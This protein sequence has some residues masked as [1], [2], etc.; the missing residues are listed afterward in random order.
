MDNIKQKPFYYWEID[1]NGQLVQAY[2]SLVSDFY[3]YRIDDIPKIGYSENPSEEFISYLSRQKIFFESLMS[4]ILGTENYV[5]GSFEL[6]LEN[7]TSSRTINTFIILKIV[8][9]KGPRSS[10]EYQ[11]QF[12]ALFPADY[13]L[14]EITDASEKERILFLNDKKVVEI[15]KTPR[16]LPIGKVN[17]TAPIASEVWQ[18]DETELTPC[19]LPYVLSIELRVNELINFYKALQ[20]CDEPVMVRFSL[21]LCEIYTQEKL[22]SQSYEKRIHRGYPTTDVSNVSATFTKYITADHLY[23]IKIQV[24]CKNMSRAKSIANIFCGQLSNSGQGLGSNSIYSAYP[25][26]GDPKG[27]EYDWSYCN[28]FHH[29]FWQYGLQQPSGKIKVI[30]TR[31]PY[32]YNNIEYLMPFRIPFSMPAG[33]PG[34]F[35]KPV[36]PF[37]QPNPKRENKPSDAGPLPVK[38]IS[39]GKVQGSAKKAKDQLD[40]RIPIEDL[41]KHGLI[42]GTTGSGK[43]N[44]TLNILKELQREGIPFLLIEPTKSEYHDKLKDHFKKTG[45]PLHV[46]KFKNPF[47][48]DG[49]VNPEFL[50]FNPLIPAPG[51]SVVQHISYIKSCFCA[52]F[53]IQGIAPLVL[54]E[55]LLEQYKKYYA[56]KPESFLFD[57]NES[58]SHHYKPGKKNTKRLDNLTLYNL[59]AIIDKILDVKEAMYSQEEKDTLG[60]YLKR[61]IRFLTRSI[62]GHSFC[63]EKWANIYGESEEIDPN[64]TRIFNEPTIIELDDLADNDEKALIMAFILT[65][66][67]EY[68]KK[69]GDLHITIIE[70]AHRLLGTGNASSPGS[71]EDG[72]KFMEDSKSKSINLFVDML[73]EIRAKGEG[74]L[75]VEQIP[76]KL[77][78]DAIKNTNLKIMHRI[79]SKDDRDYLGEAMNMSAMQRSYVT[80]LK[81]GEAIVF[82]ENL[83]APIFIKV[84]EF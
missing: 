59:P 31:L 49:S 80:N 8:F 42:V 36:K 55:A 37:Y 18:S 21:A 53:P 51:I 17:I 11:Q 65:Y 66:L 48:E 22:V 24:S 16:L 28:H 40:Y 29:D 20:E 41:T 19:R 72:G 83:D 30:M 74:I 26:E 56:G 38:T 32:L 13:E 71:T 6:R 64:L 46:F 81:M 47:K 14:L 84:N 3:V 39:L 76:K 12:E 1:K 60:G 54:E 15:L 25:L 62:L 69:K 79:T 9:L 27:A 35:T 61:R 50:R 45:T 4:T 63:P 52:A 5:T 33:L 68:R 57:G 67:F 7:N 77:V 82:D 2:D 10:K 34:M 73:A 70:E 58:P 44:T 23:S 43:T 75:I 78:S